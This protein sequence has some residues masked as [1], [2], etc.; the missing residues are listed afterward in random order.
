MDRQAS[1]NMNSNVNEIKTINTDSGNS[2]V[3]QFSYMRI[4]A[5]F[6]IVILHELFASTTDSYFGGVMSESDWMFEYIAEHMLMWAVPVFLMITGA[7]QLNPDRKLTKGKLFKK[8]IRRVALALAVFTLIFTILDWAF[9]AGYDESLPLVLVWLK[10]LF[11]GQSWAHMWYIYLL[12]GIYL[13]L[14]FFKAGWNHLSESG[15]KYLIVVLLIFNSAVGMINN[16]LPY[17]GESYAGGIAF[18]IHIATIYPVY[19][20]LGDWLLRHRMKLGTAIILTAVC[21]AVLIICAI[22]QRSVDPITSGMLD[23]IHQYNSLFVA[24][25]AAGAFAIM[26]YIKA[27]AGRFIRIVDDCTFGIYIIHMIGIHMVM[28]WMGWNPYMYG[29]FAFL[30]LAVLLFAAS[31]VLTWLIRK[32]SRIGL[33]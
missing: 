4:I 10:K 12:I 9:D 11:L 2:R 3:G 19:L 16:V 23:C 22:V 20:F 5:C 29:P 30:I 6:A 24:G 1:I 21:S 27:P 26:M 14:P 17:I 18:G 31:F 33:L 15:K 25:Q 8:Y 28:K 13:L 32:I 7:L